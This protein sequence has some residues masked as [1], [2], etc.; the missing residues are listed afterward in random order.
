MTLKSLMV[1]DLDSV[2]F[3]TNEFADSA[4]Y[5]SK[6]GAISNKAI[7][8]IIDY[9][10]NPQATEYG[11]AEMATIHVKRS[12]VSRPEIYDTII[13]DEIE[14]VVRQKISGGDVAVLSCEASKRQN[15][16]G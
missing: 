16:K 11:T 2:F 13:F 5:N 7:K 15:P 8:I 10:V 9:N 4:V 3:N 14:F 1:S 6:D 12:D